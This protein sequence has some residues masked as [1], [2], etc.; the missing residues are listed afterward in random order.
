MLKLLVLTMP[1][2]A[3]FQYVLL[4]GLGVHR[5]AWRYISLRE[6]VRILQALTIAAAIL[7]CIRVLAPQVQQ[8]IPYAWY[9]QI[10]LGVIAANYGLAFL[11]VV[12][13]RVV[14]RVAAEHSATQ[15]LPKSNNAVPTLLI[16]AGRAGEV[17]AREI[18]NR[19]DIGINPVAFIDDDRM[20][21]GTTLHGIPVVGTTDR[22]AHWASKN[23]AKQVLITM[24]GGQGKDIRRIA[25]ACRDAAL[26]V[27][28]IPGLFEI[29]EGKVN[30]SRI[31]E[32]AIE[33]LLGRDPVALDTGLIERMIQGKRVLVTGAGGSIG[34]EIC[35]QIAGFSPACIILAERAEYHLFSVHQEL[36]NTFPHVPLKPRLC[37]ICDSRRV[38]TIF[39]HE[40]P[41]IV[42]HAAAHK[43]VPMVEWNPGEAIK[44]NIFGTKKVAD[45]ADKYGA[46]A[47]VFISTDKAVNPTS[48][49]GATKRIAEIYIQALSARSQTKYVAVRFG[50][51]LGSAGSVIP[52]FK[53]QIAAGGPVTVTHPEMKRYFM[54]IPEACQLVMQ[55]AVMGTS[56]EILVLD[57]GESVRIVDLAR[58]LIRLS[59]LEPGIDIQ[60]A[61]SGIR[62]GEK[63]FE[64]LGF[65]QEKMSK[66]RH[67]KIYVGKLSPYPW[68]EVL[69]H[70]QRLALVTG[71][72]NAEQVRV[73]LKSV[74]PE[75]Q[76]DARRSVSPESFPPESTQGLEQ[77]VEALR[78]VPAS[79]AAN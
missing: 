36:V 26:P 58:D 54:T 44:N 15:H 21:V 38:D 30:L 75:M 2:I 25:D 37:D 13:V 41:E 55:S 5:F 40:S 53:A 34:S 42:F 67:P 10:P 3:A 59:G 17:T 6:S 46:E 77:V 11:G 8:I 72:L 50:N 57:M 52:T 29:L 20:K 22:L 65:D 18:L 4:A 68:N 7:V 79:F 71:A 31:R 47:F 45:A 28:I 33:D 78:P 74:V 66:T 27:K 23:D 63:L 14:R 1:Y 35:R 9:G 24:A 76:E 64:E 43:H 62:E 19:P 69:A 48:I 51:V 16:G 49:M 32:V 70:L 60:I 61:F 73:A 12:G 56:G 39:R